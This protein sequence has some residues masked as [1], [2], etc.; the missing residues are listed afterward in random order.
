LNYSPSGSLTC[1]PAN[2]TLSSSNRPQPYR[3]SETGM[4]LSQWDDEVSHHQQAWKYPQ[5]PSTVGFLG[6]IVTFVT[7]VTVVGAGEGRSGVGTLASPMGAGARQVGSG[8]GTGR[9]ATQGS[10]PFLA[11]RFTKYLPSREPLCF[12]G[13]CPWLHSCTSWYTRWQ[14]WVPTNNR[15]AIAAT[16]MRRFTGDLDLGTVSPQTS[17]RLCVAVRGS[18]AR[19]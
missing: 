3:I 16:L 13:K 18:P 14:R 9:R 12:N 1:P 2:A 17:P 15:P 7:F 11:A 8:S 4:L 6:Q 10:P 5:W 19:L